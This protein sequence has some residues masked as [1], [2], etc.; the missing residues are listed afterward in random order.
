MRNTIIVT[1]SVLFI[2]FISLTIYQNNKYNNNW[3]YKTAFEGRINDIV[4]LINE[5]GTYLN[6]DSIWYSLSYN[7]IFEEQNLIGSKIEKRIN[8]D[9]IWIEHIKDT[10][11]LVFYWALGNIVKDSKKVKQLNQIKQN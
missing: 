2:L 4:H 8:E 7:K 1:L 5:K 3:K 11:S 6:V 9:G 10:D